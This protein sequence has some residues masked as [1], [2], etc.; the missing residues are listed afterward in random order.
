MKVT[1]VDKENKAGEQV[2]LNPRIFEV[3]PK[4]DLLHQ[5]VRMQLARRRSGTA[6][7]KTRSEVGGGSRKP[8]R[9][10]GTGR[11]RA[12]TARSPLWVGGGTVFGPKPRSYDFAVPKKMRRSALKGALSAKAAEGKLLLVEE[13]DF[14][15]PKTKQMVSCLADWGLSGRKVLILDAQKKRN[16]V[17]SLS[18]IPGVDLLPVEGL[19]VY[20]LLWHEN[21][22]LTKAAL[23][24]I[25]K[26][27]G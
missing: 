13:L 20:D 14:P 2:E 4:L 18:N 23:A 8:W 25:E 1:C 17:K 3:Q 21:L 16:V 26:R 19:N 10:K 11:A 12:G 5:V 7:T 15:Q 22:V 9:Q 24:E 6:C 27:L